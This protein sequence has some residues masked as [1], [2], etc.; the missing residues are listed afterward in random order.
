M[1]K[2]IANVD[3]M[4][5]ECP[6]D[7][8]Y[9]CCSKLGGDDLMRE[10]GSE[11]WK[12]AKQHIRDNETFYLSGRTALDVIIKDAVKTYGVTSVLLP[13]YC[14][15]TMIDPILI[16]GVEI[17]FYDVYVEDGI[18]TADIPEPEEHEMIYIMRYFGDTG[19]RY[20]GVGKSLSGWNVTVEDL[21]HSCFTDAYYSLSDYWF[22][23]YRKWF[24][25]SGIAV[26]GKRDGKLPE[27]KKG[28]HRSYTELRDR[29]FSLKQRF[30]D[31]ENMDK[32]DFLGVFSK[33]EWLLTTDYL[34]YG[35]GY[36]E[37]H[38]LFQFMDQLD[39]VRLRRRRNAQILI[40]GLRTI[41]GIKVFANF[42]EAKECPFFVPIIVERG[43]RDAL[44]R[45]LISKDIYCP[46]HWPLS[47][48]HIGLSDRAK[49]IYGKELSLVCDQR[50]GVEDMERFVQEIKSFW[51]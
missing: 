11:F 3:T 51:I 33:A 25:V 48:Q 50:Y 7:V 46:V 15:H 31:G 34:D 21:T 35:V 24:A 1:I 9:G 19:I 23:S 18:L 22:T 26:A 17:R 30:M 40:D 43:K 27:A 29:A 37:I 47:E 38:N 42:K 5:D 45:H 13:S 44:R 49:E 28:F 32:Q 8:V 16:N 6:T 41:D 12:L 14:C 4:G 10:I 2:T 20:V 39:V 36:E